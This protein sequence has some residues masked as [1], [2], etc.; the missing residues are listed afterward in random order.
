VPSR[1]PVESVS[2]SPRDKDRERQPENRERE[3]DIEAER[4][5]ESG[6]ALGRA[7]ADFILTLSRAASAASRAGKAQTNGQRAPPILFCE[8]PRAAKHARQL[9]GPAACLA[10]AGGR[11]KWS[12]RR[13][14]PSC[15]F[16]EDDLPARGQALRHVYRSVA[17]D[18]GIN[19]VLVRL[20]IG[21][22]LHGINKNYITKHV[23]TS[24]P[25][26]REAQRKISRRIVALL[27]L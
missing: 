7:A 27:G 9:G 20:L 3:L 24:G 23:L 15:E 13:F 6:R 1:A 26:M 25:R 18:L 12:T 22:S 11:R 14:F 19:E 4:R 2:P 8:L 10:R 16:I 5:A 17:A 21:H